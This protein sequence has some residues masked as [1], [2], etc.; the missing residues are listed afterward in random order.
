MEH[1]IT[2]QQTACE[3]TAT[4][5]HNVFLIS[6]SRTRDRGVFACVCARS[7]EAILIGN[8]GQWQRAHI[9]SGRFSPFSHVVCR[10][11]S[12]A[13]MLDVSGLQKIKWLKFCMPVKKGARKMSVR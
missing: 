1:I 7:M 9:G 4:G 10:R 12:P 2:A 11:L 5:W 8:R 13:G 6:S 3:V